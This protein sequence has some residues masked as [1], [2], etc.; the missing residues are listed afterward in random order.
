MIDMS[1]VTRN[2][3]YVALVLL[4]VKTARFP[5]QRTHVTLEEDNSPSLTVVSL[6]GL[7]IYRT[8]HFAL[9]ILM[10]RHLQRLNISTGSP[11][12]PLT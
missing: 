3:Q 10:H 2:G 5:I 12:Q 1:S 11:S 9:C 8:Y 7:K 4:G 6:K